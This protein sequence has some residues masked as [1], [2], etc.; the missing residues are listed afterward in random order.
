MDKKRKYRDLEKFK[1]THLNE[2][3]KNLIFSI[4]LIQP[5]NSGNIGSIC[6]IMKNFNFNNLILFNPKVSNE[7]IYSYETQG[8]AMHGK[9]ILFKSNIIEINESRNHIEILNQ[10]LKE[11]DL[12]LGT[13]AKGTH[14]SN[15]NRLSIFPE[16]FHIPITE[17]PLKI[18][19]LFGKESRG[20]TN[21][22]LLLTD[23]SLRIPTSSIYPTLNLSHACGIILYEIFKK[24]NFINIGRG[25]NPVLLADREDR[26]ILYQF[27]ENIIEILKIRKHKKNNA[28]IAFRNIFERNFMSKKELSM[29]TGFFSKINLILK[30]LKLYE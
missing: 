20:L 23:I 27:I 30:D 28:F 25:K 13:T 19:L 22:E 18:A 3:Y 17:K 4:I 12:V 5:E 2:I 26:K 21:E 6:R 29:I 8:Y 16:D 10:Y 15:L 7:E 9:D 1:E 14:Y 24:I 11:F